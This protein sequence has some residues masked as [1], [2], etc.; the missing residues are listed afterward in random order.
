MTLSDCALA[1]QV[2]RAEVGEISSADKPVG[3]SIVFGPVV[4]LHETPVAIAMRTI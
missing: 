4:S 3:G 1:V 2:M